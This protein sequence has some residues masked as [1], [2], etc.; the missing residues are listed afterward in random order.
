MIYRPG[1]QFEIENRSIV[2]RKKCLLRY[3]AANGAVEDCQPATWDPELR[4]DE[5]YACVWE[6]R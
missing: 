4:F 5:P 2:I 1:S 3:C 6:E